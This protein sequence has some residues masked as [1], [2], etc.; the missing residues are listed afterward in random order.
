MGKVLVQL[1]DVHHCEIYTNAHI[2]FAQM[3]VTHVV[4][5]A[6]HILVYRQTLLMKHTQPRRALS[7]RL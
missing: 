3:F 7:P 4:N 1:V 5:H 6:F 2:M